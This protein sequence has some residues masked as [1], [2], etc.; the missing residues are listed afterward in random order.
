M[1]AASAD[2]GVGAGSG[3]GVGAGESLQKVQ[4][5]F[6][7]HMST[8]APSQVPYKY[9][10]VGSDLNGQLICLHVH[11]MA[12]AHVSSNSSCLP[13]PASPCKQRPQT[14]ASARAAGL[15][16]VQVNRS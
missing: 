10:D 4:S 12:L 3:A 2:D 11:S 5:S 6:K 15:V 1:Q 13:P 16:S 8:G 14:T 9:Q 7:L